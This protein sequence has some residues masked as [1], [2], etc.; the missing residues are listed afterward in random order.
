MY[1]KNCG[2]CLTDNCNQCPA[3]GK[4]INNM[5]GKMQGIQNYGERSSI[6]LNVSKFVGGIAIIVAVV[7]LILTFAPWIECVSEDYDIMEEECMFWNTSKACDKY[8]DYSE[9]DLYEVYTGDSGLIKVS[10]GIVTLGFLFV[11]AALGEMFMKNGRNYDTGIGLF[12]VLIFVGSIM[13]IIN[14][15]QFGKTDIIVQFHFTPVVF[16]EIILS[17]VT[18]VLSIVSSISKLRRTVLYL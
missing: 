18:F 5:D 10:Y 11:F 13:Y 1:C 6:S 3:C 12:A 7:M 8:I 15:I 9:S 17:I 2:L 4:V 16:I 14:I